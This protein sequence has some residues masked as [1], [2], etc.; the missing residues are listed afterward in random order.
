M[1]SDGAGK[2][3]R[4]APERQVRRAELE[5]AIPAIRA[6][7]KD[8]AAV[9]MLCLRPDYGQRRFVE[10]I[11]VTRAEGIPGERWATRPWL[12]LP[13]GAPHP[14]IQVCILQRR[15]LDLVWRDRDRVAHP[16]D[17][18]VVDMD[19]SED[20]LPA[21]QYLQA[22]S[23]V[24]RVSAV[25]NEACAKWR[26]RYGSDAKDWVAAPENRRHRLRG[27]LC[28]VMAD[29]TIRAGDRLQKL[30]GRPRG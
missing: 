2:T 28:R 10:E 9:E 11:R 29:G 20:N 4:V 18:F 27:I 17:S 13:S 21:G 6:A 15:V 8:G 14:G 26:H 5:A 23:A 22:G 3:A 7:P 1:S 19:L 30:A 16:G 24:L 12:R 25:F